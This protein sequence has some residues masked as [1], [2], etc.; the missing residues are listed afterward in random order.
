MH[1]LVVVYCGADLL[2]CYYYPVR[3][4]IVRCVLADDNCLL[5]VKNLPE[6]VTKEMLEEVFDN[7][8]DVRLPL[9][10][11]GGFRGYALFTDF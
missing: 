2:S 6:D 11:E 7:A 8:K 4:N 10:A 1:A 9:N 3:G 5:F